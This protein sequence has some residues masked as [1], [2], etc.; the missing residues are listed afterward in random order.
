MANRPEWVR[1][2][3]SVRVRPKEIDKTI[4]LSTSCEDRPMHE[5]RLQSLSKGP[6]RLSLLKKDEVFEEHMLKTKERK[7]KEKCLSY[8]YGID[9]LT[10]SNCYSS[11]QH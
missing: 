7:R 2:I 9:G 6:L 11:S 10:V 3:K 8:I 1:L 5:N 4:G